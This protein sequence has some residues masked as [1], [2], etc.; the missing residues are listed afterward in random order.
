VRQ[1]RGAAGERQVAGA[2]IAVAHG[3]GGVL[4]STGTVVLGTEATR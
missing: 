2:E 4:S 1:L 3:C